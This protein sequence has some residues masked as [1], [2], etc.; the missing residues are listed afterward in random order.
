MKFFH[1]Y[2]LSIIP[3]LIGFYLIW[4]P[5]AAWIPWGL[6][7]LAVVIAFDDFYQHMRQRKYPLYHS[8]LHRLYGQTLYKIPII[9][10]LNRAVDKLFS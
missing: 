2:Y 1:H 7:G 9:R 10:K 4:Q 3:G 6:L 8:P 5:V